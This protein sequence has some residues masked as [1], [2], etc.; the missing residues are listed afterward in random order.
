MIL[1]PLSVDEGNVAVDGSFEINGI[2]GRRKLQL[3]QFDPGWTIY[4]VLQGRSDVTQAGVEVTS[5][6]TTEVT[7]V[8]RQR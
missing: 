8:V 6:I 3:V 2:Y 4:S 5:G 1:N 7:I